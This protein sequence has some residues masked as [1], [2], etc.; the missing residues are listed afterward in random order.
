MATDDIGPVR[1]EI[2]ASQVS[3]AFADPKA[4]TLEVPISLEEEITD[5]LAA[6]MADVTDKQYVI[7]LQNLPAVSSRQ[8]GI[9]LTIRKICE[10]LGPVRVEGVSQGVRYLLD[11]TRMSQYFDLSPSAS[12]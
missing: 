10:P 8:L 4:M 2:D 11:L 12:A 9:M 5:Y 6:H 1:I 7:D 3:F